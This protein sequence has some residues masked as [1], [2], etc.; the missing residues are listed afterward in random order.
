MHC[1]WCR[2]MKYCPVTS[3]VYFRCCFSHHCCMEQ[4]KKL[5][6][7]AE[8]TSRS[9]VVC[10]DH[11]PKCKFGLEDVC[12]F[13]ITVYQSITDWAPPY[14]WCAS[15]EKEDRIKWLTTFHQ[16]LLQSWSIE[17]KAT[18]SLCKMWSCQD[19]R[20]ALVFFDWRQRTPVGVFTFTNSTKAS[21]SLSCSDL[22]VGHI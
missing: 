12:C 11:T 15:S 19:E 4:V 2:K 3:T 20:I 8:R 9:E 21:H 16:C 5:G 18:T 13:L 10:F 14:L 6:C 1:D 7:H 22:T 17:V